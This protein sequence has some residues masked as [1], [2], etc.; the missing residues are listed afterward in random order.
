[1]NFTIFFAISMSF[2]R[3]HLH[4]K[5][6][7][8]SNL[9]YVIRNYKGSQ[10]NCNCNDMIDLADSPDTRTGVTG[11]FG[12]CEEHNILVKLMINGSVLWPIIGQVI[13]NL[14]FS[15]RLHHRCSESSIR[16]VG[17]GHNLNVGFIFVIHRSITT[18]LK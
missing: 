10:Q 11:A 9:T 3:A 17:R 4:K 8:I 1:M 5:K 15:I 7:L 16:V 14:P 12:E 6:K 18:P 13:N 2:T